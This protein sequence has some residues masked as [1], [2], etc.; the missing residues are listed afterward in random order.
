MVAPKTI[1]I[2]SL[3][4]RTSIMTARPLSAVAASLPHA[5]TEGLG[6][7]GEPKKRKRLTNLSPEERMMRRKLKNRV[8]AQT[9]RD[10]KKQRMDELEIILAE[11][12]A[13]NKRLQAENDALKR[14]SGRLATE[15]IQLK[16]RLGQ[17][18]VGEVGG[19]ESVVLKMESSGSAVSFTPQQQ[20]QVPSAAPHVIQ[21]SPNP[22]PPSTPTQSRL[23]QMIVMLSLMCSLISSKSSPVI[24]RKKRMTTTT[25]AV[26]RLQPSL[27]RQKAHHLVWW[28]RHQ[29]NWNP[30]MI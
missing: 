2:T 15:N 3:P 11:I 8:A 24:S 27:Q 9:A 26:K 5:V 4:A 22:P 18:A 16:E 28:G 6:I 1:V 12:E 25:A 20:G 30:S 19:D 14:K 21:S 10:R 7:N 13:E 17:M 23:A 29:Q